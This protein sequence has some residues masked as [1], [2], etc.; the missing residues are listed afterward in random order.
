MDYPSWISES[1]ID[2]YHKSGL[3]KL[4][5]WQYDLLINDKIRYPL[6]SNLL[7]SAP[8]SA[9]KTIVAEILALHTIIETNRAALFVFPFISVAKEKFRNL[10]KLWRNFNLR[11]CGYMG[12]NSAPLTAWDTAICTIEKANSLINK[13]IDE[14]ALERISVIIIDE[15]HMIFD[16]HRGQIVEN[17]IAKI[18]YASKKLNNHIQIIGMSATLPNLEKLSKWLNAFS[19][20]S[21][22]RPV[23]LSQL[24]LTNNTLKDINTMETKKICS[25]CMESLYAKQSVLIFC[26]SKAE[27]EKISLNFVSYMIDVDFDSRRLSSLLDLDQLSIFLKKFHSRTQSN[28]ELLRKTI[29][30]GVAF[31]HAGLTVE[32]REEIEDGF[33]NGLLK[34][35]C[36]TSTLSS[37]VNLPAQKVIIKAQFNGPL[38]LSSITYHQMIGRAGRLGQTVDVDFLSKKLDID[39]IANCSAK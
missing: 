30:Y 15:F 18:R 3:K 27:T 25:L 24:I 2:V 21:D 33:R 37:G 19:I 38:A 5:Q 28:D 34:I 22:F 35:L 20:A 13:S 8:T 17:M 26:S 4:F 7:Y 6:S 1:I 23:H 10:Q 36:A 32:E 14:D 16:P 39:V 31:H 29:P 11:V 9:G 12:P